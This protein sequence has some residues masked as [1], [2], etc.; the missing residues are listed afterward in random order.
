MAKLKL[1][2]GGGVDATV[3]ISINTDG[4]FVEVEHN[5]KNPIVPAPELEDR[6]RELKHKLLQSCGYLGT[7]TIVNS[8]DFKATKAQKTAAAKHV[9]ILMSKT[10]VTGV[11]CSGQDQNEGVIISG[12]IQAENGSNIAMN[13]PRMRYTSNV[14]GWEGDL[15]NEVLTIQDELFQYLYEGKKAQL[16]AFSAKEQGLGGDSTIGQEPE[17][18]PEPEVGDEK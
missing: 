15:E 12:R 13:S 16:D 4:S 8:K 3:K 7:M 17:G 11:H 9:D 6:I 18:D 1:L 10:T 5:E 14:F 2:K